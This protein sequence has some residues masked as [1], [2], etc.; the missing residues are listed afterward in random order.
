MAE[1]VFK[2]SLSF[3]H[4]WTAVILTLFSYH[5]RLFTNL[6]LLVY[7]TSKQAHKNKCFSSHAATKAW[8]NVVLS[9]G[10]DIS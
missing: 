2:P 8:R 9:L 5:S 3:T 4:E 7:P 10:L 6:T 1:G